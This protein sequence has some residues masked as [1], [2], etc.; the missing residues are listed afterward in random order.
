MADPIKIT[1]EELNSLLDLRERIRT[2]VESIGRLN[3]KRHFIQLE[4][5]QTIEDLD[6]A[7]STAEELS[8]EENRVVQEITTKYGEGDLDFG[9]GIYTQR[10]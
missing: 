4:L 5:N 1:Q 6:Q 8:M 9:T 2:N 3:I 7:Y 10:D